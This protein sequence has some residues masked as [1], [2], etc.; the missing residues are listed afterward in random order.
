MGPT[1]R[2]RLILDLI[3][4]ENVSDDIIPLFAG[5]REHWHTCVGR[6]ESNQQRRARHPRGGG[7]VWKS[8]CSR[9]WRAN[10]PRDRRVTPRANLLRQSKAFFWVADRLRVAEVDCGGERQKS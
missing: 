10:L 1:K 8:G 9:V 4:A 3:Q 2:R 7:K 5:E 6:G